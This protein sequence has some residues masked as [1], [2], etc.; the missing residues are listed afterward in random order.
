MCLSSI[1]DPDGIPVSYFYHVNILTTNNLLKLLFMK[2]ISTSR[3]VQAWL[4]IPGFLF[5][6]FLLPASCN[7]IS[8]P[9][10]LGKEGNGGQHSFSPEMVLLWNGATE[11]ATNR[12]AA[13]IPPMPE[14]RIF[15]IVF[16]SMHDALNNIIPKYKTYAYHSQIPHS[17]ANPDAAVAQAAHDAIIGL[18]P[19]A[20]PYAD[21]LLQVS[22]Q[23]V[24]DGPGKNL[25][26]QL[27]KNAAQAILALRANDGSATAQIPYV[28]GTLPGQYRATPPFDVAGPMQGFVAVPGWGQVMPFSM[29]SGS[30]FRIVPDYE[31]NS[32][33]Y[34]KDYNEVKSYG[35]AVNSKRTADQTQIGLFFLENV[36]SVFNRVAKNLAIENNLDA[37]KA[38][39][40]FAILQIG[41][42]DDNIGCFESKFYYNFWRPITGVRLGDSDGNTG[43]KGDPAWDV[44]AP[45]TPPIPDYPSNHASNGGAAAEILKDYFGKDNVTIDMTTTSLPGITRTYNSFSLAARDNSLSRIYAGYHFRNA[46]M[47]GEEQGYKIGKWVFDHELKE[48]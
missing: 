34:S 44:L 45:I 21:S 33:D 37:W 3:S 18:L 41:Q 15:A 14:A 11:E 13:G 46:A 4:G 31:V 39:R 28:Q 10:D 17:D 19:P 8:L 38:A 24:P 5:L 26:I 32:A 7:K 1:K 27:G 36:C 40:L 48:N 20:A 9:L 25:G 23:S 47:K 22:L 29:K 43:T 30:Q 42:A 12:A 6:L 2:K 16:I 35:A